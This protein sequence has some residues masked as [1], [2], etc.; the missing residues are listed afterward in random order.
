[1]ICK[2]TINKNYRLDVY[3]IRQFKE[4]LDNHLTQ[5][6]NAFGYIEIVSDLS[7]GLASQAILK[8][9]KHLIRWAKIQRLENRLLLEF[10]IKVLQGELLRF[11]SLDVGELEILYYSTP[12]LEPHYPM[13]EALGY[14]RRNVECTSAV[15]KFIIKNESR[16]GALDFKEI[17]IKKTKEPIV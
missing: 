16:F 7:P 6:D 12:Q 17:F 11:D 8:A 1:M 9:Y 10:K 3:S 13:V 2:I 5:L 4:Y 15:E 14:H